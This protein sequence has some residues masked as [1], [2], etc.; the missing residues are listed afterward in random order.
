MSSVNTLS[1]HL[2]VNSSPKDGKIIASSNLKPFA[3]N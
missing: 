1:T 2:T 3:D